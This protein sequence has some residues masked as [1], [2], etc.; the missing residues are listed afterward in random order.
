[1]PAA[2]NLQIDF[3]ALRNCHMLF[4]GRSSRSC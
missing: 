4:P 1:L 2:L 3:T